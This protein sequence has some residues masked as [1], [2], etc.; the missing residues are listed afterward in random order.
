MTG[1]LSRQYEPGD[2]PGAE[3]RLQQ[4]VQASYAVLSLKHLIPRKVMKYS[5]RWQLRP[6]AGAPVG[7]GRENRGSRTR[8][9][10]MAG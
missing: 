9:G 4:L 8:P 3:P 2:V 6:G 5:H 1:E 10:S 7:T